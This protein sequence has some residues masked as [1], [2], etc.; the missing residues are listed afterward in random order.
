VAE[1][2]YELAEE[3]YAAGTMELLEVKNAEQ[4]L[5]Q[6]R[7]DLLNARYTFLSGMLDLRYLAGGE[8]E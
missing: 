7:Y 1:E 2:A 5:N 8:L 6:A 4:E 3:S